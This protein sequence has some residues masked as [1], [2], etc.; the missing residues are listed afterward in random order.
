MAGRGELGIRPPNPGRRIGAFSAANW[1]GRR[2]ISSLHF[3]CKDSGYR[4]LNFPLSLISEGSPVGHPG[5][6]S[7]FD[8]GYDKS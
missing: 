5:L 3:R 1:R 6:L 2:R 8:N 7:D 4:Y